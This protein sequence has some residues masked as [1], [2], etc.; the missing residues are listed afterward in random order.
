MVQMVQSD[1]QINSYRQRL[2]NRLE[3]ARNFLAR[4]LETEPAY[5]DLIATFDDLCARLKSSPK[6]VAKIVSPTAAMASSLKAKSEDRLSSLYDLET[7]SPIGNIRSI[8]QHCDLIFLLYLSHHEIRPH[9]RQLIESAQQEHV[10]LS[11]LVSQSNH[12]EAKANLAD[13]LAANY[14]DEKLLPL[15][16]FIDLE[17]TAQLDLYQRIADR[18]SSSCSG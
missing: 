15:A 14:V 18:F 8:L 17:N 6:L 9:H 16:E 11:I 7:V 3:Q 13:W 10:S 5:D 1:R 12:P 2:L 4:R